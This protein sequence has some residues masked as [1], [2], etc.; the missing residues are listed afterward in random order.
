MVFKAGHNFMLRF[1]RDFTF[2]RRKIKVNGIFV[3]FKE[4][5]VAEFAFFIELLIKLNEGSLYFAGNI[6]G[7]SVHIAELYVLLQEN[8][9]IN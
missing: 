1:E 7:P 3:E 9:A 2:I 5:E 6:N 8:V 4:D